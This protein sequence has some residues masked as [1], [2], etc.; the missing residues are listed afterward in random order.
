M[1]RPLRE[2]HRHMHD[3]AGVPRAGQHITGSSANVRT[4]R[5]QGV[6]AV[7]DVGTAQAVVTR[8][9]TASVLRPH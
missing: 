6:G 8:Q 3:T 1:L 5:A 7:W 9:A 4:G 2:G